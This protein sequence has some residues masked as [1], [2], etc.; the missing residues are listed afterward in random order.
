MLH[1]STNKRL[2][3]ELIKFWYRYADIVMS[4]YLIKRTENKDVYTS[5]YSEM[6]SCP[7]CSLIFKNIEI[8]WDGKALICGPSFHESGKFLGYIHQESLYKLWNSEK[9]NQLRIG[10]RYR[11]FD[12][13]QMCK[14]C[15]GQ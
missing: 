10:Q 12:A 8:T 3:K 5:L 4:Q 7:K 2:E 1:L 15:E 6:K 9:M 11:K 13:I 14:G